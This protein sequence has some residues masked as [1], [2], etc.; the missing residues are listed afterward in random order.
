MLLGNF[1]SFIGKK[2]WENNRRG[3]LDWSLQKARE[4]TFVHQ[5]RHYVN[6]WKNAT[7]NGEILEDSLLLGTFIFQ[8][9]HDPNHPANKG[10]QKMLK[11]TRWILWSGPKPRH[12]LHRAN[13]H[14]AWQSWNSL[15]VTVER[16]AEKPDWDSSTHTPSWGYNQWWNY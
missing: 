14:T 15:A 11:A 1:T 3:K 8:Q 6:G 5:T 9:D 12:Q 10:E 13:P 4:G 7:Q 16:R 2:K